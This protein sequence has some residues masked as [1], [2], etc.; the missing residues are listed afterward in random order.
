MEDKITRVMVMLACVVMGLAIG[1]VACYNAIYQGLSASLAGSIVVSSA[2]ES[3]GAAKYDEI[4]AIVDSYFIGD[5]V[6]ETETADAMAAAVVESL[7]DRWSYYVSADE[8]QEYLDSI[9]NS[10]VGVGITISAAYDD[11]G[12]LTGYE[13]VSVTEG[14]PAEAAGV[15]AGDILI[16]ADDTS[17]TDISLNE[18]KSIVKGVEGTTVTL[19]FVRG[20]ETIVLP[21]TR[22]S[23]TVIPA[24]GEL[25]NGTVGYI[26]IDNFDSGCANAVIEL[27]QQLQ[28]EGAQ[29]LLFDVRN[30]PG[31]LKTELTTLLDY[32]LPEGTIFDSVD[33]TGAEE[34]V[35]SDAA[36]VDLPMAVLVNGNSYSAAEYFACALQEYGV[37]TVVGEQT[38]GK[39]Y[40]QTGIALSDGSCLNLSVGKYYTPNGISLIDVGVTPDIE[41]TLE[42]DLAADLAY[43]RLDYEDDPQLQA[44][45]QVLMD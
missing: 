29:T 26:E 36:C 3:E 32:L 7:G 1:L 44:A 13:V 16:A 19:T 5:E 39:G 21:V 27:V 24:S 37:A 4:M 11:A 31:G 22:Q 14:G 43:G 15:L 42:D 38:C 40:F 41:L 34:I 20:D 23:F 33:Y 6:D 12:N 35:T 9:D 17:V 30:N 45:L 25:L 8:Y 10:Y 18:V 28:A 2:G